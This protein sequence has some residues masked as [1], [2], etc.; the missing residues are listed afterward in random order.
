MTT[1]HL[2][3]T[4]CIDVTSAKTARSV[5][6]FTAAHFGKGASEGQVYY[7]YAQYQDSWERRGVD[8]W[9]IVYRNL[10]YMVRLS[11]GSS[12]SRD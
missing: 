5:T 8:S 3:G 12:L 7:A 11:P 10:V 1:Q 9:R 2:L 6:Y 4:Q